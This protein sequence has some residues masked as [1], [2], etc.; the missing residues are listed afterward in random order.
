MYY[1]HK[2]IPSSLLA[3][4]FSGAELPRDTVNPRDGNTAAGA[5]SPDGTPGRMQCLK[6]LV[7][8][9][10]PSAPGTS[11]THKLQRSFPCA[12]ACCPWRKGF[13]DPELWLS[14][15]TPIPLR[16]H[17]H[18]VPFPLRSMGSPLLLCGSP[19]SSDECSQAFDDHAIQCCQ[20][21]FSQ[22]LM[23]NLR[24]RA[25]GNWEES[26]LALLLRNPHNYTGFHTIPAISQRQHGAL[27]PLKS[28][29]WSRHEWEEI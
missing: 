4:E 5:P 19:A 9:S 18:E 20:L 21:Q 13:A 2:T 8:H 28:P 11:T 10:Y 27:Q 26:P 1:L 22:S 15:H 25:G 16:S 17:S 12:R 23:F 3:D 24:A 14:L 7:T 6:R 29:L